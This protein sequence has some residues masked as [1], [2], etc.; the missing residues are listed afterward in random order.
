MMMDGHGQVRGGSAFHI[1][2][3]RAVAWWSSTIAA[4]RETGQTDR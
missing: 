2:H 4:E 3:H 1:D